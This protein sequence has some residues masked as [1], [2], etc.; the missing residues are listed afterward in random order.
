VILVSLDGGADW[1]LDRWMAE[2]KAPA[3]SRIA[4][5]GTVAEGMITAWP[6]LTAAAHATL[7]TG[8]SARTHGVVG[9]LV[10]MLPAVEH[11]ILEQ[12]SGYLSG[13]LTAE[14]IWITAARAG[15][16]VLVL[17][18]SQGAP[19][20]KQFPDRLLQFDVFANEVARM[21][22][23]E[24]SLATGPHRFTIGDQPALIEAGPDG[25]VR[26]TVRNQRAPLHPTAGR[27][28]SGTLRVTVHGR[29]GFFRAGLLSYDPRSG[30]FVLMRGRVS[31]ISS[32]DAAERDRF[33][34]AAGTIMDHGLLPLYARGRLGPTL[35]QGGHGD[36]EEVFAEALSVNQ[37]FMDGALAY[38]ARRPWQLLVAYNPNLDVLQHTFLG[39]VDPASSA[40]T[41]KIAA[42]MWPHLERM[43]ARSADQYIARIRQQFPDATIVI[44][45]DHGTEGTG[46]TLYPNAILAQA[47]LL[48]VG[49]DGQI[50]LSRT[51][52]VHLEG[53]AG[54]IV[55]NS[56]AWKSGIVGD[57]ERDA[58]KRAVTRALLDARDPETGANVV[59]AVFDAERDGEGLGFG[60]PGVDLIFDPSPDYAASA[61]VGRSV[62]AESSGSL[63]KGEHGASPF[64]R[65]LHGIFFAV[66]PGVQPAG[67]L[68]IIRSVDVAPTV[69]ALLGLAP[70]EHSIGGV[71]PIQKQE[72]D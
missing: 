21:A 44:T 3:F 61:A 55:V 53:R 5:E 71:L 54:T 70:P 2:G 24:G 65:K 60:G 10:P 35:V 66:G 12:Q 14:P 31:D 62:I 41:P 50:D 68:P 26:L 1:L 49:A 47:G 38:A 18:A 6:S 33:V 23:V 52:A 46:R 25:S 8:A 16:Q 32:S 64:R 48:H 20:T 69:A 9:N 59:R 56:R 28:W 4:S 11:T 51:R 58:V 13:V 36:A 27:R 7:W 72:P 57:E 40:Y 37:E 45:S 63:G 17:Q 15:R 29:D 34:A 30:A 22:L 43:F 42:R 39:L 19:F 67:R